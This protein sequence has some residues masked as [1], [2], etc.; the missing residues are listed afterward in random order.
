LDYNIQSQMLKSYTNR[1]S[2]RFKKRSRDVLGEDGGDEDDSMKLSNEDK[3]PQ[4]RRYLTFPK[5][6]NAPGNYS[7]RAAMNDKVRIVVLSLS[8]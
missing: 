4:H 7:Q 5:V 1:F 2:I 3:A 6:G 8:Y